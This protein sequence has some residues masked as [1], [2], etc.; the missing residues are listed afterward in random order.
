MISLINS[1]IFLSFRIGPMNTELKQRKMPVQR[2][3]V[4]HTES[5]QPEQVCMLHPNVVIPQM[6]SNKLK[7]L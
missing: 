7:K 5:A 1:S 4:R 3:R 6:T 2:K